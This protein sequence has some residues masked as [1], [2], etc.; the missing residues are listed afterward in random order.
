[1]KTFH[2]QMLSPDRAFYIGE[3]VSL[4]VPVFDGMLG[5]M[6]DHLPITAAIFDGE[7]SFTLPNGEKRVCA[8]SKGMLDVGQSGVR[9]LCGEML[10]PDEIDEGRELYYAKKA[11]EELKIKQS[12]KK[13]AL[14]ELSLAEAMNNLNVKKHHTLKN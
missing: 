9:V 7:V 5:I 14:L 3:C 11:E 12:R 6:A 8:V 4:V 2:L 13:Y 10:S 1:M